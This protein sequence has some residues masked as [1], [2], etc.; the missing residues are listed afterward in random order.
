VASR[1][2][3]TN[4]FG[5]AIERQAE[6]PEPRWP[7]LLVVILVGVVRSAVSIEESDRQHQFP[8]VWISETGGTLGRAFPD[9]KEL[10]DRAWRR[11]LSFQSGAGNGEDYRGSPFEFASCQSLWSVVV[12]VQEARTYID[13]LAKT[14][15]CTDCL[16]RQLVCLR[17][18]SQC[19]SETVI[20]IRG[21]G[22]G[23]GKG[24]AW[25]GF[26]V[27]TLGIDT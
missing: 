1:V 26:R 14:I 12:P 18:E 15:D 8:G 17:G 24:G 27:T 11:H 21:D 5:A 7:D 20:E 10:L 19:A 16:G 23:G 25:A 6:F 22:G 4:P 13:I 9:S 3:A 2:S